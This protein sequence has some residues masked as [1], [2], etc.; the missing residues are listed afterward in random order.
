MFSSVELRCCCWGGVLLLYSPDV[1]SSR[2]CRGHSTTTR[3]RSNMRS[4]RGLPLRPF[5]FEKAHAPVPHCDFDCCRHDCRESYLESPSSF[6]ACASSIWTP[7]PSSYGTNARNGHAPVATVLLAHES[8]DPN[9]GADVNGK[10][11]FLFF[12]NEPLPDVTCRET[13]GSQ[14]LV[15]GVRF[16]RLGAPDA[17][18]LD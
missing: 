18:R 7:H 11:G 5:R 17:H 2:R 15:H 14:S 8:R 6:T 3:S 16:R 9:M 1:Q 13:R 4:K 12:I 10:T